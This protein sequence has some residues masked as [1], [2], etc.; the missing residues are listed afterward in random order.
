MTTTLRFRALPVVAFA[1]LALAACGDDDPTLPDDA[2]TEAEVVALI[3][4]LFETAVDPSF[5][6]DG[7]A[8]APAATARVSFPID[9]SVPCVLGGSIR[10]R[11]SVTVTLDDEESGTYEHEITQTHQNCGVRP[12]SLDATFVFAG[13]PSIVST[14]EAEIEGGEVVD[15]EGAEE[16][17]VRWTL[18]ERQGRCEVDLEYA[19]S[20]TVPTDPSIRVTGTVCGRQVDR[21]LP[22]A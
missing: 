1:T 4:A 3:E 10:M 2:L 7:A 9:E 15:F 22:T 16:G 21:L 17:T 13:A 6:D 14:M 12:P 8:G 18:G 5:P 19:I 11:G 20:A